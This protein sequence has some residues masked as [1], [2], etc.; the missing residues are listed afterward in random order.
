M[1]DL[2]PRFWETV[3]LTKMTP[4]EW[5]ALCDGCGKCCLNKLE[6]EDTGEVLLTCVA[7]RLFD[8]ET[9]RCSD[10]ANRK[11]HVPECVILTPKTI[12][13][14][15]YWMPATCAYKLLYYKEKLPEWHP[16]Q[17]GNPESTHEMGPSIRG[18]TLS[19]LTVPEEDWE[20]YI[21]EEEL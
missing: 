13:K 14:S 7:C 4:T 20:D 9:A 8:N 12:A 6:F 16:L 10:Y 5:E 1:S 15:A 21:I 3:P 2:R 19:E 11:Q 18:T 17:T